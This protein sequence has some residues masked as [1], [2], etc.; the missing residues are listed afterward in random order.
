M[1]DRIEVRYHFHVTL[2]FDLHSFVLL[3]GLLSF[4]NFLLA[5]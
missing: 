3:R 2:C 1:G 4:A 5:L